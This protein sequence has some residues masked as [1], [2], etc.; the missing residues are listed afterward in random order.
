MQ[1]IISA[2]INV[3]VFTLYRRD[4]KTQTRLGFFC[5]L[6]LQQGMLHA[7]TATRSFYGTILFSYDNV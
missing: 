7:K 1:R 4:A 3:V 2:E 6:S 5:F